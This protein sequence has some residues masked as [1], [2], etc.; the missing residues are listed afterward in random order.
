MRRWCYMVMQ[1]TVT[2]LVP[3]LQSWYRHCAR[4]RES[5]L[6]NTL[7]INCA[8][9][10]KL[11]I[12]TVYTATCNYPHWLYKIMAVV[13]VILL[14]FIQSLVLVLPSSADPTGTKCAPAPG[15]SESCVCQTKDGIIDMTSLSNDNE[16]ARYIHVAKRSFSLAHSKRGEGGGGLICFSCRCGGNHWGPKKISLNTP[17]VNVIDLWSSTSSG[18]ITSSA[19]NVCNHWLY[20][21]LC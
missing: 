9:A 3:R 15:R 6:C 2:S 18:M 19:I 5:K 16:T 11:L 10:P 17:L 4:A 13:S 14:I 21:M 7:Y 20:S 12:V 1:H 8:V